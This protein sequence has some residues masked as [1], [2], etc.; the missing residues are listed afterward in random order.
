MVSVTTRTV[1]LGTEVSIC[2]LR[3]PDNALGENWLVN[4]FDPY[5]TVSKGVNTVV[6]D[7]PSE[8]EAVKA[9][10]SVNKSIVG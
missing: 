6:Y 3:S 8:E 1:D 9:Y 5:A 10:N 7:G 2:R 4:R